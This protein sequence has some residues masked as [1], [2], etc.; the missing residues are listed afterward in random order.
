MYVHA[1]LMTY[2]CA[3]LQFGSTMNH[4][5]GMTEGTFDAAVPDSDL[6]PNT[7]GRMTHRHASRSHL[8]ISEAC[9]AEILIRA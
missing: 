5:L 3:V 7:T 9:L 4:T 8:L 1:Q 6:L 2:V